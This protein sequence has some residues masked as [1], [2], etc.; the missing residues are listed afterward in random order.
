MFIAPSPGS[1]N[2]F[3]EFDIGKKQ[4][5]TALTKGHIYSFGQS[6]S[7]YKRVYVPENPQPIDIEGVPGPGQYNDRTNMIGT[8]QG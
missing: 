5:S 8:S 1:Y 2:Q 6:F 3:S 4:G 7:K